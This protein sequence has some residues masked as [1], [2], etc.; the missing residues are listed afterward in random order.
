MT[1]TKNEQNGIPFELP[2]IYY[3]VG[4][5]FVGS[6]LPSQLI[7][8]Q[9]ELR[10]IQKIYTSHE[11]FVQSY[12]YLV[13]K[14]GTNIT[15][16]AIV[17]K[18]RIGG[19]AR[20]IQI[21]RMEK[22]AKRFVYMYHE[23]CWPMLDLAIFLV[24]PLGVLTPQVKIEYMFKPTTYKYL[25]ARLGLIKGLECLFQSTLFKYYHTSNDGLDGDLI[26]S[27]A[28]LYPKSIAISDLH[29]QVVPPSSIRSKLPK[30]LILTGTDCVKSEEIINLYNDIIDIG[31]NLNFEILIKNHPN[32]EVRLNFHRDEAEVISPTI[33]CE[34][35]N[36]D[37]TIVIGIASA[38]MARF[39]PRSISVINLLETMDLD[40][41]RQRKAF[42]RS[43]NPLAKF[44]KNLNSIFDN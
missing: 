22:S 13:E 18:S 36:D 44:P 43:V 40:D 7:E 9:L 41:K 32:P 19:I 12:E 29:P 33:P 34:L 5:A 14:T 31:I 37:F 1:A 16:E 26:V 28:R 42:L 11:K 24:R 30:L 21:L 6:T 20:Y 38:A 10:K 39:G 35:L 17:S 2:T 8:K 25:F 23:C 15:V 3:N 4:V 27:A